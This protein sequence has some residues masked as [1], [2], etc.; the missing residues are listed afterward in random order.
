MLHGPWGACGGGPFQLID[1]GNTDSNSI[2]LDQKPG[3]WEY[4]P[5]PSP[6]GG[7]Y[8]VIFVTSDGTR[9]VTLPEWAYLDG[10]N[11]LLRLSFSGGVA[12]YADLTL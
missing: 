5:K 12:F 9:V 11:P 4:I 8:Q 10:A 7:A 1:G 3:S 6:W 2:R